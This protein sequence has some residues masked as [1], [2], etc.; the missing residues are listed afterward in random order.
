MRRLFEPAFSGGAC[1]VKT[2]QMATRSRSRIPAFF[3]LC[4]SF[5]IVLS[6]PGQAAASSLL[7]TIKQINPAGDTQ[8]ITCAAKQRCLVTMGLIEGSSM[9]RENVTVQIDFVPGALLL[10]FQTPR[11]YLY[12]GEKLPGNNND[13]Y[14]VIWHRAL[15][16]GQASTEDV[17]LY[18]PVVTNPVLAPI[19]SMA[20]EAAQNIAHPAIATLEIT[21]QPAP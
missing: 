13:N 2:I 5:F 21:T 4:V 15:T 20:H 12:A 3:L 19:L 18:S 9:Q 1:F 16:S 11:G 14:E 17:T 10:E 6:A 7:V 8:T